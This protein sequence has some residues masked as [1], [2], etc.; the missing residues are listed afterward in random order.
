MVADFVIM[1]VMY[2]V[3]FTS[4]IYPKWETRVSYKHVIKYLHSKFSQFDLCLLIKYIEANSKQQK[5]AKSFFF[6][7][8][9]VNYCTRFIYA[10][11]VFF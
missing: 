9:N 7:Y 10:V 4:W 2:I 3:L 1:I 5:K 11:M 8:G 6:L